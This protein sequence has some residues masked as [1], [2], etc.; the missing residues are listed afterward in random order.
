MAKE[1]GHVAD[2]QTAHQIEPVYF[3]GPDAYV[4]MMRDFAVRES[5]SDQPQYFLLPWGQRAGG[6]TLTRVTASCSF[7]LAGASLSHIST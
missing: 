2:L 5:L 4:E 7:P 6:A 1:L 3:H